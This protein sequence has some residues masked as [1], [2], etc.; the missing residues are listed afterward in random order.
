MTTCAAMDPS[1][2]TARTTSDNKVAVID[3]IAHVR[4]VT[5]NHA[6]SIYKRL[7]DED[8][9]PTCTMQSLPPRVD[10]SVTTKCQHT[11]RR[12]GGFSCASQY[13][14]VATA[15]EMVEIIWAL[16]GNAEF[17]RN[18]AQIAV[19]YLGGDETLVEEIRTNR[20]AQACL[21][22]T[23]P[24]H[25]ACVFGQAVDNEVT[26][27]RTHLEIAELDERIK[28]SKRR[29]IEDGLLSLERCGLP[30]DD[31]DKMRAKDCLNSITFGSAEL[32][33]EDPEICVRQVL[34]ERGI[35]NPTMDSRVGKVAKQLYL[36][37]HPGYVFPK[38]TIQVNG[39]MLP[40][41]VW[42]KSQQSYVERALET[43]VRNG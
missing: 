12:S 41:N 7:C 18:C 24:D 23:Q 27:K 21:A 22:Q 43:L 5:H 31:R 2:W 29:C 11:Q 6:A 9:A 28:A 25:P 30:I 17:R 3:V 26:Q 4:N 34:T 13:T 35:R 19:R 32:Q 42:Y 40:A 16:P 8:R 15:A 36:Q 14:P 20:K 1:T 10:L 39:Q 33:Q 38:K 37:D